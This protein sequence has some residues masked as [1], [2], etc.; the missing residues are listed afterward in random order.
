MNASLRR[1]LVVVTAGLAILVGGVVVPSSPASAYTTV[2]YSGAGPNVPRISVIGDSVGSG[3]RWTRSYAPLSVFNFTFDAESCR[4]TIT[5]SCRGREGYAPL[6][7]LDT[8]RRLHGY[9]GDVLVLMTGYN[10]AGIIFGA[11]VDAV[12]AEAAR[13]G[14][15]KVIWLTMRTADVSYVSPGYASSAS[16]FRDNNRILLQKAQ[17]YGGALQ[18]ADWATYS[19]NHPSWVGP[20]GVHLSVR[21]APIAATFI[22]DEAR[23]VLDGL[24]ITP[25]T[26]HVGFGPAVTSMAPGQA[27]A[28]VVGADGGLYLNNFNGSTGS[29]YGPIG[30]QSTSTPAAASPSPGVFDVFIRGAD[31]ALWTRRWDGSSWGPW[32]SLGGHLRAAPTVTSR[33]PG[34]LDLFVVGGD[35]AL[36]TRSFDGSSWSEWTSLGGYVTATPSAA[37]AKDGTM[38][39]VARGS[40]NAVWGRSWNGAWGDWWTLGGY[41]TAPPSSAA[42]SPGKLDVFARGVDNA[43]WTIRFDGRWGEWFHVG[44]AF[45]SAPAAVALPTRR[46]RRV[47]HRWRRRVVGDDGHRRRIPALDQPR[48][49]P[50]LARHHRRR[51]GNRSN[52]R[53]LLT[54]VIDSSSA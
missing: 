38:T 45:Y 5:T 10:D 30:G 44:G 25:P 13:Q 50:S 49:R 2:V 1:N 43:L 51:T 39:I 11:G 9:L 48:R 14:V 28:A 7:V 46:G 41:V 52:A 3:I 47:R 26:G 35:R 36:W 6:N 40:D 54:T 27:T 16:T 20:D 12:M 17:Q 34:T 31:Y 23:K 53:S 33:S 21:G 42:R 8:M 37:S 18:V 19:A 24:T 15:P 29:G 32:V 4:R 22:A